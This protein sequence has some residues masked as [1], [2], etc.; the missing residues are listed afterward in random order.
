[1][2]LLQKCSDYKYGGSKACALSC[3]H[4]N[5][6]EGRA[7]GGSG[8]SSRP[9]RR[10]RTW[11][12][13][14]SCERGFDAVTVAEVARRRTSQSRPSSITSRPRKICSSTRPAGGPGR[15]RRSGRR[16]S[17]GDVV[18]ALKQHYAAGDPGRVQAG[19]CRPGGVQRARSRRARRCWP[20]GGR[21]PRRWRSCWSRRC[22]SAIEQLSGLMARLIAASTPPRR[23]CSRPSWPSSSGTMRRGTARGA[24]ASSSSGRRGVRSTGSEAGEKF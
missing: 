20:G 7:G 2:W 9:G 4:G 13:T 8:R 19:I 1:M 14:C 17:G 16:G 11:R 24:N 5:A 22:G 12:P 21:T 10:S 15:L 23:R 6:V 18:E 3:V